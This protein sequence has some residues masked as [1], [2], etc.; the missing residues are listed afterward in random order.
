LLS[1]DEQTDLI[2]LTWHW[3]TAYR[4]DVID[5][6]WRAIPHADKATVLTADSA[7]DLRQLIRDDYA[8]RTRPSRVYGDLAERMST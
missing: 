5:G 7:W 1:P 6:V 4:I 8:A 3:D 2:D